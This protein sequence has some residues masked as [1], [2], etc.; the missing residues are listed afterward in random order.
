[1][2]YEHFS[3]GDFKK[4]P[5][6]FSTSV[7]WSCEPIGTSQAELSYH[8]PWAKHLWGNLDIF[9]H[10][11]L[12]NIE[13]FSLPSKSSVFSQQ[14]ILNAGWVKNHRAGSSPPV[15]ISREESLRNECGSSHTFFWRHMWLLSCHGG[16]VCSLRVMSWSLLNMF[17][18]HTKRHLPCD[19]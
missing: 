12:P 8:L 5:G 3:W 10:V 6:L 16:G 1:M 4:N 19:Y 15:T 9:R 13:T 14:I 18:I 7:D 2:E 17:I 11:M